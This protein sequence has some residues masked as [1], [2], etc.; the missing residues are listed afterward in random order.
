MKVASNDASKQSPSSQGS[1]LTPATRD[2]A[3]L[4]AK[5]IA[6][7]VLPTHQPHTIGAPEAQGRELPRP[8]LPWTHCVPPPA[9]NG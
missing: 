6:D 3:H 2:A 5:S 1:K 7:L 4:S 8:L 9:G